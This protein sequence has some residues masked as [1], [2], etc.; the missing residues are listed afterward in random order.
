MKMPLNMSHDDILKLAEEVA[1]YKL[2]KPESINDTESAIK[3]IAAAMRNLEHEVFAILHLDNR[4]KVIAFEEMFRGT[5]DGASV[6]PREVAKSALLKNSAAII[7]AHNHPSGCV[8]PSR[9]D[10]Q[11]TK[12][13]SESLA[14][15]DIRLLDHIIVGESEYSFA[16]MGLL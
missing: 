1:R 4:H 9:A 10:I 15:L 12:R 11:I 7:V 13:L 8:E 6:H 3:Y 14:L 2:S 5:I 16:N